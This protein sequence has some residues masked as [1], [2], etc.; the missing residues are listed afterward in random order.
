[1]GTVTPTFAW[2]LVMKLGNRINKIYV[3]FSF[4]QNIDYMERTWASF[5]HQQT[6]NMKLNL[7]VLAYHM[8]WKFGG[9]TW[10]GAKWILHLHMLEIAF[11]FFNIGICQPVDIF[12]VKVASNPTPS[13]NRVED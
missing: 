10:A 4:Y 9:E 13:F 8:C 12:Q 1:M 11:A 6:L 2:E 5:T 3:K 7:E